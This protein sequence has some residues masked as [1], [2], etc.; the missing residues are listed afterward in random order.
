MGAIAHHTKMVS[1]WYITVRLLYYY[2]NNQQEGCTNCLLNLPSIFLALQLKNKQVLPR[3]HAGTHCCTI[4]LRWTGRLAFYKGAPQRPNMPSPA[5]MVCSTKTVLVELVH[6][7]A[8]F[9]LAQRGHE[10]SVPLCSG[11]GDHRYKA[12]RCERL[13]LRIRFTV[14]KNQ[15]GLHEMFIPSKKNYGMTVLRSL[16]CAAADG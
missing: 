15:P 8:C 7:W 9:N 4:S 14:V 6:W 12:V 11:T 5:M 1:V 10:G 16:Q 2:C 13:N 3:H